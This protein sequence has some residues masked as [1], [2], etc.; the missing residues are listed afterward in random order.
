MSNEEES[1]FLATLLEKDSFTNEDVRD[2]NNKILK[3]ILRHHKLS[4]QGNKEDLKRRILNDIPNENNNNTDVEMI[5]PKKRKEHDID[6]DLLNKQEFTNDDIKDL[7]VDQLKKI[8]KKHDIKTSGRKD[9]LID[10][11]LNTISPPDDAFDDAVTEDMDVGLEKLPI[12]EEQEEDDDEPTNGV[13]DILDRDEYDEGFLVNLNIKQ[14]RTI[15]IGRGLKSSGLKEELIE[16]CLSQIPMP[17]YEPPTTGISYDEDPHSITFTVKQADKCGI[18]CKRCNQEIDQGR[19]KVVY[20]SKKK[21]NSSMH[22]ECFCRYP[23]AGVMGKPFESLI[24]EDSEEAHVN[25]MEQVYN[26]Y[27]QVIN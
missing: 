12:E 23:P 4:L 2:L 6:E 25:E 11:I 27:R 24:F 16:R 9:E 10:R 17:A 14:L 3:D 13:N 18:P 15:L 1:Q 19:L 21:K 22:I 7:H 20:T 8:L 5:T 26:N